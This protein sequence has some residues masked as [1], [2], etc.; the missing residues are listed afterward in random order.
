MNRRHCILTTTLAA[1]GSAL[2]PWAFAAHDG[3]IGA[4]EA[5]EWTRINREAAEKL[6]AI[7]PDSTEL[8]KADQ[9]LLTEIAIGGMIQLELSRV[10]AANATSGDVKAYAEAE[11]EEQTGLAAKLK[12]IAGAK[13]AILPELPA[14]KMKEAIDKMKAVDAPEFDAVY[15]GASGVDGHQGLEA[16]MK[17]VQSS[18]D[19]GILKQVAETALP[20]IRIHLQAAKDEMKDKG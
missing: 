15:L 8:S 7:K 10:A 11:V 17:K 9:E 5:S 2:T 19:D 6:K 20:L 4:I 16:T 13:G 14:D 12:E 1:A 18:A 3:K